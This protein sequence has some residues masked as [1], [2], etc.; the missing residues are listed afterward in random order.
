MILVLSAKLNG[1]IPF[2]LVSFESLRI[3]LLLFPFHLFNLLE[4]VSHQRVA[5]VQVHDVVSG[6][7]SDER[8]H[9]VHF[10]HHFEHRDEIQQLAVAFV[11]VPVY[12]RQCVLRLELV[13]HRRVVHDYHVF[14]VS[15]QVGQVF[16]ESVVVI[17]A[18][19]AE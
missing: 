3:A 1:Q 10:T 2:A 4:I 14:H 9:V 6:G 16:H 18:V 17:S 12:R 13:T 5:Q 7:L 15:S 8:T 11:V 19:V